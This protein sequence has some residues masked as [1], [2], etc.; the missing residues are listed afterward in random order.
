MAHHGPAAKGIV[1]AHNT[2]IGDARYTDMAEDAM[3]NIGQLI[4][5]GHKRA[6]VVLV[7]FGSYQGGVIAADRWDAPMESL[8]VPPARAGSW[9]DILHRAGADD[10]LLLMPEVDQAGTLLARRG[11]RAIGVVYHPEYEH[12]GNY[13]PT[14]LSQRYDAFLYLDE[15]QA[16]HPLH[17]VP[18]TEQE[19]TDT[20]PTG[21]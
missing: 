12:L 9:E 5:E 19:V 20:Y 3:V 2:H 10:K 16:L 21:V 13:V 6:D 17:L 11:Q 8:R 4:R 14:V 1:W 15:T 7:G 18:R